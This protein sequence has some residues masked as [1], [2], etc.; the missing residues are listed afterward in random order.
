[1]DTNLLRQKQTLPQDLQ[2]DLNLVF[3]PFQRWHQAE[4]DRWIALAHPLEEAVAGL[5]YYELPTAESNRALDR[6]FLNQ[7][8]RAG[9]PGLRTREHTI[10]LYLNQGDFRT[11]L[12]MPGEEPIYLLV[13]DR[14]GEELFRERGASGAEA[15]AS[16]W[17]MLL[18]MAPGGTRPKAK[19]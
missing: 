7:G 1:V 3:V 13:I 12:D 17:S 16:L 9:I 11:A 6:F 15:E 10:P 19:P 4:V 5:A 2:G 14:Q 8:M 18:R